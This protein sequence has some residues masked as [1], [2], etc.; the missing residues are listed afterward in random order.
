MY[1]CIL[2]AISPRVQ[3]AYL[4]T[5]LTTCLPRY[6]W[7]AR[8][9]L[10]IHV[11]IYL[12]ADID[13]LWHGR[14]CAAS[15]LAARRGSEFFGFIGFQ[16]LRSASELESARSFRGWNSSVCSPEST[17]VEAVG[18]RALFARCQP[19]ASASSPCVQEI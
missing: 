9:E 1:A 7:L 5:C 10:S 12:P 14:R 16:H 19:R 3:P 15:P 8:W 13:Y 2:M 18:E 6:S 4:Q 11:S 17:W